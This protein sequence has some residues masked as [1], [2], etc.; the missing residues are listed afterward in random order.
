[1]K[2]ITSIFILSFLTICGLK[3]TATEA[4][5]RSCKA[6]KAIMN[7]RC[8]LAKKRPSRTN[9]KACRNATNRY[10]SCLRAGSKN[11]EIVNHVAH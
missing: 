2:K 6:Q 11:R 4:H 3:V 1:M 10:N 8:S 7:V 9:Q 5:A